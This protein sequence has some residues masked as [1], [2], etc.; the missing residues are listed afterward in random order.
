MEQYRG[1][2]AT[3]PN[4]PDHQFSWFDATAG[5]STPYDDD[6]HGTHV[7]GTMVG[8]EPDG[9]NAVG[10]APGAKW[11]TVKAFTP[12]GGTDRDLLAAGE[13][14]LAPTDETRVLNRINGIVWPF[15]F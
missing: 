12:A 8:V 15:I 14:I 1:Y 13:W 5:Q 10:V 6:G 7:T 3:A 4:S 11:V 9:S 2:D